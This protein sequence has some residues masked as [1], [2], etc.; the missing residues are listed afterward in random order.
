M[1]AVT[2]LVGRGSPEMQHVR[3]LVTQAYMLYSDVEAKILYY[4]LQMM[5]PLLLCC[6]QGE[7]ATKRHT[8]CGTTGE[9]YMSPSKCGCFGSAS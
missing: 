4:L 9:T 6:Q 1:C 5:I 2:I 3:L 7:E 8:A